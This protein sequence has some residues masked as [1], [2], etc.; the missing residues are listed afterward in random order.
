ML[1]AQSVLAK[2]VKR[3]RKLQSKSQRQM[4]DQAGVSQKTISNLETEDSPVSPKLATVSAVANYFKIHPAMLLIEGVTDDA[5]TDSQT[6]RMV[7]S[8]ARLPERRKRQVMDLIE[9]YSKLQN[10]C[11]A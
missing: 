7:E 9:D 4:S 2:N 1:D 6:K 10:S 8:F 5:L 11:G 3:L